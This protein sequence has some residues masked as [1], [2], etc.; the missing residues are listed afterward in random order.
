MLTLLRTRTFDEW[1][2]RLADLR[3]RARVLAR[4]KSATY[5]NFGDC[6]AVGEGVSEMRIHHGPGY[7]VYFFRNGS[8]MYV[9]L[10]GGD[11]STQ[12]RDIELAKALAR[13]IREQDT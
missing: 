12:G 10:C 13:E 8:T 4:L 1:I 2:A 7:R 6:D 5:G 3:G 9:V 11:K